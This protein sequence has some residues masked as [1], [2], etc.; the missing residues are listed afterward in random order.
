MATAT[1]G[2]RQASKMPAADS[3][4]PSATIRLRSSG[5]NKRSSATRSDDC[6]AAPQNG[7]ARSLIRT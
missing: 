7:H 6:S 2:S 5:D 3:A 4:A 1:A